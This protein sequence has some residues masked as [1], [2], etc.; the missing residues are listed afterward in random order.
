MLGGEIDVDVRCARHLLVQEALEKEV[1]LDRIDAGDAEHVS[2]DRI[3][4]R[5]A[6]LARHAVLARKTHEVPVDE[7]E[8]GEPCL[9]DHLQLSLESLRDGERDWPIT[10]PHA[11][12]AEL[13]EKRE[14]C[15]TLRNGIARETD[16]AEVEVDIALLRD[17]PWHRERFSVT[18]E[19]WTHLVTTLEAVLGVGEQV[20]P[21]LVQGGPVPDGHQHVI[22]AATFAVVVVDLV[23]GHAG[24][25]A[26]PGHRRASLEQPWIFW[27]KVVMELAE[28][29]L[30]AE[31]LLEAM[32]ALL[33]VGRAEVE[34]IASVLGDCREP[35]SR[36]ALGLVCMG[37]G[38]E[39][40]EVRVAAQVAGDQHQFGPIDLQGRAEILL[41]E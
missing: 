5:A 22:Q 32:Q 33:V 37:E 11:L 19:E 27:T 28:H 23:G 7:E 24:R 21:R 15:L 35:G 6:T 10:L 13:V 34:E 14:R 16:F 26:L 39:P 3:G 29:V 20:R 17:L 30:L 41:I 4:G 25:A 2:D 12:E 18:F 40:A 36:L 31:R 38:E 9:L 1:V 8:L